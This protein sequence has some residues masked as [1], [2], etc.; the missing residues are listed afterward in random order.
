[1]EILT[2]SKI[3]NFLKDQNQMGLDEE[4]IQGLL[5]ED[6]VSPLDLAEFEKEQIEILATNMRKPKGNEIP[7]FDQE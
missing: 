4:A 6:I 3:I 5:S 2:E 1:M 7:H